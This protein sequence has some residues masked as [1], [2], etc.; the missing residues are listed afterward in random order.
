MRERK[1]STKRKLENLR[2]FSGVSFC[3]SGGCCL[4]CGISRWSERWR[5]R[6]LCM[7]CR[8]FDLRNFKVEREMAEAEIMYAI[9]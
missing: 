3:G 8:K 4:T 9:P 2:L 7:Q 1:K 6:R 5:R